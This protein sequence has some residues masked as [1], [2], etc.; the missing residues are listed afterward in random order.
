MASTYEPIA[1]TTL[2]SSVSTIDFS[3]ITS[4]YTDLVVIITAKMSNTTDIWIRINN[5][6]GS[7]YSYTVLRGT[8][9]TISSARGS[10]I[11]AGLLADSEAAPGNDNN[12]IAICQLMN[13]S[14]STTY[15]TMITRAN[16]AN[17]GVDAVVALWR[18]TSAINR[19]T[20][21]NVGG[22]TFSSGTVVTIYGIKAA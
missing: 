14:N 15:K 5:D 8:G 9:T 22:E 12:H 6:S 7:N 17:T 3:S 2:G 19:I 20:L 21:L 18:S 4:S 1:T 16:R 11:S 10:N 13:Y